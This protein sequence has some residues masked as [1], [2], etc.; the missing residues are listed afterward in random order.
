MIWLGVEPA[1]DV[2]GPA[3]KEER[4][5]E[6]VV[7]NLAIDRQGLTY[8]INITFWSQDPAKAVRIANG[9][10]EA[11]LQQQ[12]DTKSPPRVKPIR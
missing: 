8:V 9:F 3:R 6:A 11:Y 5:A 7:K 1:N 10:A 4:I 12:K 2:T